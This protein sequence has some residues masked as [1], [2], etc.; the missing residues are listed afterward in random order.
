MWDLQTLAFPAMAE[1]P[2]D[3]EFPQDSIEQG[4]LDVGLDA[5]ETAEEANVDLEAELETPTPNL[6]LRMALPFFRIVFPDLDEVQP[7]RPVPASPTTATAASTDSQPTTSDLP[8]STITIIRWNFKFLACLV[9]TVLIA[10][11]AI[12][13]LHR[14]QVPRL[15]AAMLFQ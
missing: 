9:V 12:R 3:P 13:A 4:R 10:V 8:E 5:L 14:Y 7:N 15:A 1:I 2:T 11:F 6:L